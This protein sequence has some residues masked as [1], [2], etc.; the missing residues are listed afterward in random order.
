MKKT[1]PQ[2]KP[3]APGEELRALLAEHGV[4]QAQAAA[5]IGVSVKTV[6][7]WLA[8]EDA[9]HH[10]AMPPRSLRLFVLELPAHLKGKK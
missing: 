2:K 6:E 9:A 10:R 1:K 4:T 8:P 3:K 7:S 5:L